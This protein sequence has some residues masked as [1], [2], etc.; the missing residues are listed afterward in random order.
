MK[1]Q[2]S[3][4]GIDQCDFIPGIGRNVRTKFNVFPRSSGT[5]QTIQLYTIS[6]RTIFEII[7]EN[8]GT[9]AFVSKKELNLFFID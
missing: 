9:V 4:F 6:Q 8:G 7:G 3:V 5:V 2:G 1:N